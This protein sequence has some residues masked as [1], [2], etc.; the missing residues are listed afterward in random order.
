MDCK[1]TLLWNNGG[2][3]M[4]VCYLNSSKAD[5]VTKVIGFLSKHTHTHWLKTESQGRKAQMR[6]REGYKEKCRTHTN[7]TGL[8]GPLSGTDAF[9]TVHQVHAHAAVIAR[10]WIAVVFI[11]G[12]MQKHGGRCY[13]Y[14]RVPSELNWFDRHTLARICFFDVILM[15]V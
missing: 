3:L 2:G 4:V 11:W 12:R 8:S 10:V 13:V 15:V 9:K 1:C 14:V 5:S 6:R 7:E